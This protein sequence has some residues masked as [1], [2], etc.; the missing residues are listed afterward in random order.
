[1]AVT[2]FIVALSKHSKIGLDTAPLIYHLEDNPE[3]VSLTKALLEHIEH[4]R[5]Q[6]I[7]S[8]LTL[9]EVL[10]GPLKRGERDLA[11]KYQQA[12]MVFPNL[13]IVSIETQAAVR[14]AE[15]RAKYGVKTPDALQLAVSLEWGAQA[16]VTNDRRLGKVTD[17]EILALADYAS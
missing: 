5:A 3:Y 8:T 1:V 13:E 16:F 17:L 15:L 4:G 10:I 2:D 14:A 11:R 9:T 12:L 6:A 7:T